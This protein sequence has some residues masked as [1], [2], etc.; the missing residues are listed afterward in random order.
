M[1]K[2]IKLK[3]QPTTQIGKKLETKMKKNDKREPNNPA[4]NL[5]ALQKI[6]MKKNISMHLHQ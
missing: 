5:L 4:K 1:R 6:L 3:K 2:I